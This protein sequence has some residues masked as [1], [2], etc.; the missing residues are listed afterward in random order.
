ML[1]ST[2][3][4]LILRSRQ[5]GPGVPVSPHPCQ[6]LLFSVFVIIAL[7]TRVGF[8]CISPIGN[9]EPLFICLLAICMSSL[10]EYLLESFAQFLIRLF[11]IVIES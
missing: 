9:V 8:V 1:F 2:A 3:A 11:I 7:L 6:R 5:Q 10:E 4:T